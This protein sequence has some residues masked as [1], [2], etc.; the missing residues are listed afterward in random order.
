M[1]VDYPA[2][3]QTK[4]LQDVLAAIDAAT[5]AGTLEIS[6]AS[7]V[8]VLAVFTLS[9]PSFSVAGNV[10]TMLGT[11]KTATASAQGGAASARIKDGNG[12]VIIDGLVVGSGLSSCDINFNST[13]FAAN[14][15]ITLNSATITHP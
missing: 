1:S 7:M 10:M 2:S 3:L 13:A 11:P 5:A 12:N 4:R 15:T 9:K 6:S 14:Q 8:S